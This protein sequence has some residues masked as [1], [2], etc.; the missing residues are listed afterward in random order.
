MNPRTSKEKMMPASYRL[1]YLS[2]FTLLIWQ[3]QPTLLSTKFCGNQY[4]FD[5]VDTVKGYSKTM[6]L[7]IIASKLCL[8][9]NSSY[10]LNY[11]RFHFEL[12]SSIGRRCSRGNAKPR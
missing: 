1:Q 8:K 10:F 4:G 9:Y 11:S 2:R 12:A 6:V 3:T 7:T 5:G